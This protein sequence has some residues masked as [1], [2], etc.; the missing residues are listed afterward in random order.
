MWQVSARPRSYAHMS[1]HLHTLRGDKLVTVVYRIL[2]PQSCLRGLQ[3]T[4]SQAN[5]SGSVWSGNVAKL[6]E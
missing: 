6:G 5:K 2:H 4:K 3:A 1:C